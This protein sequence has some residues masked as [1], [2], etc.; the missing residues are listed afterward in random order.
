MLSSVISS[1][2]IREAS[3]ID[4]ALSR[5][6]NQVVVNNFGGHMEF[7][8]GLTDVKSRRNTVRA[9]VLSQSFDANIQNSK[10]VYNNVVNGLRKN[11]NKVDYESPSKNFKRTALESQDDS[12]FVFNAL[13][14]LK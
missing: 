5:G 4:V 6:G 2:G 14:K 9:R 13:Y 1:S 7:Y 10:D 3:A 12:L 8:G 11:R